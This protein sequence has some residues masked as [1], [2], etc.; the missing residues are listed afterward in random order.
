MIPAMET[1]V[2]IFYHFPV[3]SSMKLH[4]K[5]KLGFFVHTVWYTIKKDSIVGFVSN[6][7]NINLANS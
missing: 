6:F 5:I 2:S 3:F 1:K 4:F 7:Y